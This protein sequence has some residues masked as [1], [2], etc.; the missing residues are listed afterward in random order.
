MGSYRRISKITSGLHHIQLTDVRRLPT[1]YPVHLLHP[2]S[3]STDALSPL[4]V[5]SCW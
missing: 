1:Q 2:S 5:E 4:T 3:E